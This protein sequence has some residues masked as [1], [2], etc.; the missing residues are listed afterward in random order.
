VDAAGSP[1]LYD[2]KAQTLATSS[3]KAEEIVSENEDGD[4]IGTAADSSDDSGPSGGALKYWRRLVHKDGDSKR[5]Y[6]ASIPVIKRKGDTLSWEMLEVPLYWHRDGANGQRLAGG[7]ITLGSNEIVDLGGIADIAGLSVME[8]QAG[9]E[10]E[11]Q[12]TNGASFAGAPT[13]IFMSKEHMEQDNSKEG[14]HNQ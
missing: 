11:K 14:N 3:I 10:E 1:K 9:A 7:K 13:A 5:F 6:Y 2:L 4:V 12:R 8:Q